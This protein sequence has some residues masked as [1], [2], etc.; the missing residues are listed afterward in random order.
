[1][2]LTTQKTLADLK[3][4]LQNPQSTDPNP[5]PVYFVFQGLPPGKWANI[6]IIQNGK[7]GEEYPKTFGHYHFAQVD[8]TYHVLA[9]EGVLQLI[10]KHMD[11][12]KWN[13]E[14]VD[15]VYLVKA[16]AGDEITIN[17]QFGHSWSNIGNF[18][19]ILFDNWRLGHKPSDYENIEHPHG[20]AYYL[21]EKDG[22]PK[23]VA[24]PNYKNIPQPVWITASEFA[25]SF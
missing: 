16:K 19:L 4:V 17:P 20:M 3:P 24:N 23:A 11:G 2:K 25:S 12:G 22:K 18:P 15:K 7:I 14:K 6:T 21:T 5:N 1:M 13:P 8:E 9:G 10:E